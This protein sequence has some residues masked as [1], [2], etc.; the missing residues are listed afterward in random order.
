MSVSPSQLADRK[1]KML[2]LLAKG[3]AD[4][5]KGEELLPTY[6]VGKAVLSPQAIRPKV[7]DPAKK[8]QRWVQAALMVALGVQLPLHGVID[9]L[10]RAALLRFQKMAGIGQSGAVDDATLRALEEAVG[11]PAPHRGSSPQPPDNLLAR[12]RRA[13]GGSPKGETDDKATEHTHVAE[14]LQAERHSFE[15]TGEDNK[16]GEADAHE[17]RP[18]QPGRG[19]AHALDPTRVAMQRFLHAEAMQAVMALA[20]ER[21][22]VHDELDRLGRQG[23]G[24]LFSEMLRWW[25]TARGGDSQPPAWM[26]EAAKLAQ[27]QQ[28]EAVARVRKAWQADHAGGANP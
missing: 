15:D 12:V 6:A 16:Y 23:D 1:R 14:D 2:R 22:W 3:G 13:K 27:H 18:G 26:Q 7:D 17:L 19:G 11:V 4:Q 8:L 10:T 28:A 24:A 5:K 9:G 20:F 25:E 21:Q